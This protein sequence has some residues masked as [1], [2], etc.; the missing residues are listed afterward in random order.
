M[1]KNPRAAQVRGRGGGRHQAQSSRTASPTSA[2]WS[3]T[4]WDARTRAL[5]HLF[6]AERAAVPQI[7]DVPSDTP[8]REIRQGGRD[9]RRHHGGISMNFLNAGI[10]VTILETKQEALRGL[11]T[12]RKL[13]TRPR[14]QEQARQD[15]YEQRMALPS[16]PR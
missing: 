10:P 3:S 5:R 9:R 2:S 4:S 13:A 15:K 6:L 12:I 8:K 16:R 1:A 14:S 7:P 11:A